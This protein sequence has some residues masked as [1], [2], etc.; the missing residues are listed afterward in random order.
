MPTRQP[1]ASSR[2]SRRAPEVH[3]RESLGPARVL[4]GVQ[5]HLRSRR[6]KGAEAIKL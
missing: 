4:V 2:H 5:P 1:S 6:G 3:V